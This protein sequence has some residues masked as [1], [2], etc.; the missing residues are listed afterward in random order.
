MRFPQAKI[1]LLVNS[2]MEVMATGHP[3]LAEV[4]SLPPGLREERGLV[5]IRQELG[6]IQRLR[7]HRF[8]LAINLS[9]GDR[10]GWFS[11]LSGASYRLGYKVPSQ[12]PRF[13]NWFYNIAVDQPADSI[14]EVEK[15]LRLLAGLAIEAKPLPL[16]FN[17]PPAVSDW[18]K[19]EITPLR[20]CARGLVHIHPTSRWMFK[21]WDP[22]RNA[23]V[24]R[25][26][27][28]RG[29]RVVL[30]TGPDLDEVK[31][32][33]AIL[34]EAAPDRFHFGDLN[35]KQL[36]ALIA[37]AEL[38]FGVDSAP[39]HIASAVK[40]P[41]IALFGPTGVENW[42]P[43]MV[44]SRVIHKDCPCKEARAEKCDWKRFSVRKCLADIT[45]EEVV[46]AI[47]SLSISIK[48]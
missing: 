24:V 4:L 35:L 16:T 23:A 41:T 20:E 21:S 17:I 30:T 22:A 6:H 18:A 8:D 28:K 47:T 9:R 42:A 44:E 38:F 5:R 14:H 36:G 45:V 32:G 34:H 39:M 12:E 40:T 48:T 29:Y 43:W 7:E 13:R 37:E 15:N 11:V 46:E 1:S 2:G 31:H 26:L 10:G 19:A 25:E 27:Q 33:Q 3:R